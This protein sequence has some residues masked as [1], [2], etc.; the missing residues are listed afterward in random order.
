MFLLNHR[1]EIIIGVV[2]RIVWI[3]PDRSYVIVF[4]RE[5]VQ[6]CST[7]LLSSAAYPDLPID[8]YDSTD[9]CFNTTP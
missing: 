5:S 2:C 9:L 7:T 4:F 6:I 3:D 1:F 8:N